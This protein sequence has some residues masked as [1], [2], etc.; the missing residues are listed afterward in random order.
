MILNFTKQQLTLSVVEN[1]I[2]IFYFFQ[3]PSIGR[4]QGKLIQKIETATVKLDSVRRT[5][6]INITYC[7]QDKKSIDYLR[8][9]SVLIPY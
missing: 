7:S 9:L 3:P 6:V 5:R 2:I 4:K 8:T 1:N